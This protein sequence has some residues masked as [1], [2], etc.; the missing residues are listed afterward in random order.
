M[1]KAANTPNPQLSITIEA[2]IAAIIRRIFGNIPPRRTP[3]RSVEKHAAHSA[4][5]HG[6]AIDA[7]SAAWPTRDRTR[8]HPGAPIPTQSRLAESPEIQCQKNKKIGRRRGASRS[9]VA[10]RYWRRINVPWEPAPKPKR[11]RRPATPPRGFPD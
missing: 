10:S 2:A 7:G 5:D 4:G 9:I 3:A 1:R 6:E 11:D 8:D